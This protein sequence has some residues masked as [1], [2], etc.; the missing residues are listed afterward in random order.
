MK[1]GWTYAV[2]SGGSAPAAPA[3]QW[4]F[5]PTGFPFTPGDHTSHGDTRYLRP[6]AAWNN[7]FITMTGGENVTASVTSGYT[8]LH[9][10]NLCSGRA[11]RVRWLLDVPNTAPGPDDRY[12]LGPPTVTGGI[13][14][15]TTS[16][17]HLVVFA[18][19]AVWPAAGNRC[20]NPAVSNAN[21][22]ANGFKLVPQPSVLANI[23]F[24]GS[25]ILTEPALAGGRVYIATGG[26]NLYMLEP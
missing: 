16:E 9:G 23:A 14:F 15:V 21:C 12:R 17:G 2:A 1:D 20:S 26:G 6:G 24:D 19:P 11:D 3:V 22:M 7:V 18:D 25:M 4:Q 8:R 5:P 13:Y 10:L